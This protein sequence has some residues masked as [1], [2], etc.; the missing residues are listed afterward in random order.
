MKT[1][2]I[3]GHGF[4]GTNLAGLLANKGHDVA[5]LSRRDG[6]DL[7]DSASVVRALDRVRPEAI[8][9][10][11]AHVGSVHYVM[12]HAATV[13]HDNLQMA[14]NLYRAVTEVA[15]RAHVINPL[16]NCSYPGVADVHY[17][18]DWWNGEVHHSVFAYGSAKRFIYVLARCYHA[19]HQVR[20]SNFLVPNTFG[21]GDHL[22]TKRTH[23]ISGMIVRMIRAR[24]AGERRF[25]VW[26]SGRPVREWGYIDDISEIVSRALEMDADLLYPVNIAQNRGATIRE[27]AEAI[28]DAVGYDGELWFNT[29]YEDGAPRKVLDDR[30]FRE[31]FPSFQFTD[32]GEAIRRT[33]D[34]YEE[35][36]KSAEAAHTSLKR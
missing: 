34:Y 3:G 6:L 11:A 30:R 35:K 21:V 19:E 4:V 17:E 2:I 14:L 1:L 5:A 32:H 10:C 15:P 23:A 29:Q 24:D 13:A 8:F 9:N 12:Q 20:T 18:P 22:D 28:R 36:L 7:T 33:V 16:S 25:E 26:G 27:S 31:L